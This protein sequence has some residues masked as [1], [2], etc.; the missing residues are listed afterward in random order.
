MHLLMFMPNH[1]PQTQGNIGNRSTNPGVSSLFNVRHFEANFEAKIKIQ[2][3][4]SQ[5]FIVS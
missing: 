3:P 5:H 1:E 2:G 4:N